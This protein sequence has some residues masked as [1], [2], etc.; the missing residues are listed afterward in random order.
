MHWYS[1]YPS[2]P[3][4]SFHP[5]AVS[6]PAGPPG[7]GPA[8]AGAR[9]PFPPP[10]LFI[11]IAVPIAGI[12]SSTLA[13]AGPG[14]AVGGPGP[15]SPSL[16]LF[17][18]GTVS[19]LSS[20]LLLS[21]TVSSLLLLSLTV[22]AIP[23]G[24]GRAVGEPGPVRAGVPAALRAAGQRDAAGARRR[25]VPPQVPAGIITINND[26]SK[27]SNSNSNSNN[28]DNNNNNNNNERTS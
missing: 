17:S 22:P 10:P 1:Y 23:R 2:I 9:A 24:Q 18:T 8:G 25:K 12:S 13:R 4:P 3:P 21:L 19:C 7:S 28:N 6:P 20:L 11:A 15:D 26:N 27:N 5:G 16:P 14:R